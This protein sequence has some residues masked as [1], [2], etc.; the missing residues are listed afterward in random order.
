M[1]H[2]TSEDAILLDTLQVRTARAALPATRTPAP[3]H[4]CMMLYAMIVCSKIGTGAFMRIR[5]S[6]E[7]DNRC[8]SR[9]HVSFI[10]G[11]MSQL[12][13]TQS[14]IIIVAFITL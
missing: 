11:E 1:K 5:P 13:S 7:G 8:P 14:T 12:K 3:K 9:S 2:D 10:H 6:A 4:P